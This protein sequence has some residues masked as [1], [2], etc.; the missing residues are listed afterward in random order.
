MDKEEN[1]TLH[2][3]KKKGL[4]DLSYLACELSSEAR[5]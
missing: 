3:I 5:Y 4:V 1:S 2:K